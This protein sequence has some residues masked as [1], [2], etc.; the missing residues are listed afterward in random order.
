[1]EK[2]KIKKT[3][4]I[5]QVFEVFV[6]FPETKEFIDQKLEEK[7]SKENISIEEVIYF[8]DKLRNKN[9]LLSHVTF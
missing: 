7:C 1:M 9:F 8:F 2:H 3:L 6:E 4:E 5:L